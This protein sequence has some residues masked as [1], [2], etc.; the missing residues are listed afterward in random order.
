MLSLPASVLTGNDRL[1]DGFILSG[2]QEA[3]ET[4][5]VI[6]VTKMP[7]QHENDGPVLSP[8]LSI[9]PSLSVS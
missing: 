3:Q 1:M 6:Y 7:P 2:W 9:R 4:K 8:A 5:H